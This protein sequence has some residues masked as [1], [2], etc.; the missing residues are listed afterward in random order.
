[1]KY[2]ACP[3]A[4]EAAYMCCF[5]A[6]DRMRAIPLTHSALQILSTPT[7]IGMKHFHKGWADTL[8]LLKQLIYECAQGLLIPL[9]L[10]FLKSDSHLIH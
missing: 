5:V 2:P 1:M 7:E 9:L 4:G 10:I 3:H 6:T 8:T